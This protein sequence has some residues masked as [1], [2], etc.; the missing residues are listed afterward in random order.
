[1]QNPALNRI[2][3]WSPSSNSQFALGYG[4]KLELVEIKK[5][6]SSGN[7]NQSKLEVKATKEIFTHPNAVQTVLCSSL[8][9]HP[10]SDSSERSILAYST[11]I[12]Q[13]FAFNWASKDEVGNFTLWSRCNPNK[14]HLIKL[15]VHNPVAASRRMC[16]GIQWNRY[17]LRYLAAG[18][19]KARR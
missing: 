19:E 10:K 2:V 7:S 9:W 8:N 17:Y 4:G 5:N 16:T 15:I 12:G 3:E 11:S 14:I 6:S 13:V 1:M 18:F